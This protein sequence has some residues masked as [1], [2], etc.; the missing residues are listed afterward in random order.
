M[1]NA[2]KPWTIF[3]TPL[4]ME[5]LGITGFPGI[6]IRAPSITAVSPDVEVVSTFDNRIVAVKRLNVLGT[7]YSLGVF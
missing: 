5:P 4:D 2:K 6:F 3:E 7:S 1:P